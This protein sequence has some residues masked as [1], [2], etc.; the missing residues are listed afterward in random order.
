MGWISTK[1]SS[2]SSLITTDGKKGSPVK[3]GRKMQ[4]QQRGL[5]SGS[6]KSSL[7]SPTSPENQ[8]QTNHSIINLMLAI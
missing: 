5:C 3:L 4:G 7:F 2:R 1:A 8:L 6:Y